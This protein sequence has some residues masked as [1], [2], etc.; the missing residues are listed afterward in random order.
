VVAE[1]NAAEEGEAFAGFRRR[2][3]RFRRRREEDAGV[4][5]EDAR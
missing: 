4:V 1:V 2:G 5:A 3:G